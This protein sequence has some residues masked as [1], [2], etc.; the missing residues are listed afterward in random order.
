MYKDV[1][2]V[3]H[4]LSLEKSELGKKKLQNV[5]VVGWGKTE[6]SG[7]KLRKLGKEGIILGD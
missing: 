5:F 2:L 6:M 4:L 7:R 1:V 3:T